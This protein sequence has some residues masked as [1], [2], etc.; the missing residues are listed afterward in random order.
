MTHNTWFIPSADLCSR[1]PREWKVCCSS[2]LD[3]EGLTRS[4]LK[5]F[6]IF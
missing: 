5:P 6:V 1:E 2:L 3:S 4:L